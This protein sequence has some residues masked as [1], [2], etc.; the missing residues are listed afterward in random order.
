[1]RVGDDD[2]MAS[3][4]SGSEEL[5][6]VSSPEVVESTPPPLPP[7][8][9][10][11][12]QPGHKAPRKLLSDDEEDEDPRALSPPPS[13]VK[14]KKTKSGKRNRGE[15]EQD[16]GAPSANA[17]G[18]EASDADTTADPGPSKRPARPTSL[19]LKLPHNAMMAKEMEF[20][21]AM[22]LAVSVLTPLKVDI[23]PLT[24]C[25]DVGTLEC[26]GKA[27]T[28]YMSE[29]RLSVPLIYTTQ[30][31]F[32]SLTARI[33]MSYVI[34]EAGLSTGGWNPSGCYVWRH[35]SDEERGLHC[36][37]GTPMISKDQLVEMDLTSENAQ[38]ALKENPT[39]T[40]VVPNKWGRQVVQLIN[41][42]AACCATDVACLGNNHSPRSCGLF[43]TEAAKALIAFKQIGEY[44]LAS[45]PNMGEA[46]REMMLA[47]LKCECNWN[48]LDGAPLHGRQLAKLTPYAITGISN[49]DR[50]QV[51][52]PKVLASLNNPA[53]LVFQCCNPVQRGRS[54]AGAKNC[55]WKISAPDTITAVQMAKQIWKAA[56]GKEA[57]AKFPEFKWGNQFQVQNVVLPTGLEDDA[58]A[59]F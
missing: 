53:V 59:P 27:V 40:K 52:D 57:S 33:L 36:F 49:I 24:M 38:R 2:Q 46:A 42:D 34:N 5:E 21:R 7:K 31:T 45:Y 51:E 23:K 25:P 55:D 9:R 29:K 32:R 17:G 26:F 18:P 13:P 22:D 37:H 54:A 14:E 19:S 50:D 20:Q 6:V 10:V 30:K 56:T 3:G 48:T 28:A 35:R 39:K 47:P 1:M 8:K 41:N 16:G 4:G 43:Y 11:P 15:G 12:R 44:Q 58:P